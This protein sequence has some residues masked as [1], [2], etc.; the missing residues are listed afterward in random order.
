MS[1]SVPLVV[2]I[3][4]P[5]MG[6][7]LALIYNESRELM[8]QWPAEEVDHLFD[9]GEYKVYYNAVYHPHNNSLEILDHVEIEPNW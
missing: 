3:Q 1:K 6:A 5:V 2:K 4:L 9:E 8:M 7:G